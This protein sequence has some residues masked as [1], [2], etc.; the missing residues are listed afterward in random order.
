MSQTSLITV[1]RARSGRAKCASSQEPIALGEMRI[2][3][4]TWRMGRSCI[5][6]QKAGSF[7]SKGLFCDVAK[8]G[9][10]S[11][12]VSGEKQPKGTL[13]FGVRT[14]PSTA[15][16]LGVDAGAHMIRQALCAADAK[17]IDIEGVAELTDEHR[18]LILK[19]CAPSKEEREEFAREHAALDGARQAD[20]SGAKGGKAKKKRK[21][22]PS[23]P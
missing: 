17:P 16:Y 15:F 5:A 8:T 11:C 4:M 19:S 9:A 21:R 13:R 2:G 6:W 1:E 18:E 20:A 14:G 7:I 12:K 22:D 3:I 23:S 10:A